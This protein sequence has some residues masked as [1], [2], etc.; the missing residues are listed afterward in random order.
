MNSLTTQ[1]INRSVGSGQLRFAADADWCR[2]PAGWELG[3][4]I[5]VA[6][7]SQ[8]RVFVFSRSSHPVLVFD[9]RGRFPLQPGGK[10]CLSRPH[11]IHIGPDDSVYCTDDRDHTVR[12]FTPEG[13]LLLTLGASGRP[14]DTG[15]TSVDYRT[16]R[17]AGPPFNFPTNV[18]LSPR[19]RPLRFR[20]LRQRADSP[21]QP[22]TAGAALL[23]C[24]RATGPASFT[25]RTASPSIARAWCTWPTARTAASNASSADGQFIDQWTDV[26][27]PCQVFIDA[28]G[29]VFVAELGYRAGMFAGQPAAASR[30]TPP[31]AG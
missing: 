29:R 16:I 2:L 4:V 31:A 24:S 6:T 10:A 5:A 3:E 19:R 12:K 22:P 26:A 9:P 7:D 15:A 28:A 14:S 18:A 1:A 21:V 30:S 23:G 11:G 25:C 8:D 27:R 17:R 20:R 13:E